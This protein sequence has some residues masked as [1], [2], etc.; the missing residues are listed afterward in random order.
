METASEGEPA[1][2]MHDDTTN[3]FSDT[4]AQENFSD[5]E[6]ICHTGTEADRP[7]VFLEL[8]TGSATLSAEVKRLGVEV[9]V[10]DHES[11][12]HQSKCKVICLD[13]SLPHAFERIVELVTK[14]NVLGVHM[15]PPCGT[16][17]KARGIPM[18]DG[19]A[20]P[21]PLRDDNYLLGLPNLGFRD[22]QRVTAANNLY[23]KLGLLVETLERLQIPWTIENPTNSFLWDLPY[24]AFAMAH[25]TKHDCHACAFG[26]SRKKLTSFLSNRDEFGA[27]SR[28]CQDVAPHEHE[29]WG[30]DHVNKCFN[31]AKEAEY[32]TMMCQQYVRVLQKFLDTDLL[33]GQSV[34]RLPQ[35]QPKGR[36]TPQLIP[37]FLDVTTCML[38]S[39][40]ALDHKRNLLKAHGPIPA[41]SRLL[42]TEADK[43]RSEKVLCVF[44]IYRSMS[45]FVECARSLWHPF[46]ELRNLPDRM[47]KALFSNLTESPHQLTKLRCQFLRKWASRASILQKAELE[48]HERMPQHVRRVM[49]GKRILVMEEL[50]KEMGWPDMQ[51]FSELREGFKLVGTFET[52]GIFKA[53]VTLANISEEELEKNTNFLRP[54]ILGRL[55]NFEDAELQKELF[56]TTMKEAM[57]KHWLEGPYEVEEI[58]RQLGDKWLPVRRFGIM[59]RDKLRPIDNF[60]E[61]MLN[62]TFGCYEKVELKAMEHV[63]WMLVTL[64]RYMRHFGEIKFVLC[65]GTLLEGHVHPAWNKVAFGMEATCVDMKSAYKQLPLNPCEYHRTVVSLWDVNNRKAACFLMRTLPFGA[66]ASV[67]H[68][69]RVSSF[70]HAVGLHA[71]LCWGAYFDDFPTLCNV[72]NRR[73]TQSTALGIFELLG[74]KYN[75]EKLDPFDKVASMLGVELD[76]R[77]ID[78]GLIKVQNKPARVTEVSECLNRILDSGVIEADSLPSYLGKLQFAEAQL[79]GRAGRIALADLREATLH[80]TGAF[81]VT[82]E[83]KEAI[84]VLLERFTTGRPRELKASVPCRPHLLFTDGA[85]EYDEFGNP[86]ASIGGVLICRDGRVL[87]FGCDVPQQLMDLW[88]V[89]GRTHVIGLVELYAAVT[90]LH[91]WREIFK[92]DRVI[93]FTDSWP[94]YDAVVKGTAGVKEWRQLLLVLEKTDE[95]HPM[96][97]WT[98]RV[99]ST[100]NPADPPSRRNI[101]DLAFLGDITI[102]DAECPVVNTFL[103][104]Y[105]MV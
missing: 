6:K 33:P 25:G 54:A 23:E 44:G 80:K 1:E 43:G 104:S 105:E 51:L 32:P 102:K 63:L 45:Q 83:A 78:N 49:E 64:A 97:L 22:K 89:S 14:C 99:P 100:S 73:S 19:S 20:G 17:S 71:G 21:Q 27:L 16:C 55:K 4:P 91:T 12:R 38:E 59:Q 96:H 60:K 98:A 34:R 30:Y 42:R 70:I 7:Y 37:E 36:K 3:S 94:A 92:D 74:F 68:F 10:F 88:Q 35:S 103:R 101:S 39:V 5:A 26:S 62:L 79:W 24:F 53:G 46:D 40:P 8:C 11:N 58:H 2:V 81:A 69:L 82:E 76:L 15:G 84:E 57:E 77:E 65:D 75:D 95:S 52:T 48:V 29:S 90:G 28:F 47:I 85:L 9:L 50:A 56:E 18:P 67:H 31:T 93:L 86:S 72:A 66:T 61:S 87:C 13:L 41:G